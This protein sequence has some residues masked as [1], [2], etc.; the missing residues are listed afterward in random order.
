MGCITK[1]AAVE[2]ATAIWEYDP[3][4]PD[5]RVLGGSLDVIAAVRTIAIKIQASGQRIE[6]FEWLQ[7]NCQINNLL[8]IP[9]HS[10]VQWGLAYHMLDCSYS[11]R[12][13]I[14]LFLKL[15]DALYGPITTDSRALQHRFSSEQLP[16]LWRALPEIKELQTAWEAKLTKI[17]LAF[18]EKPAY[19]LALALH[20]YYK[21]EYIKMA[22]GGAEEQAEEIQ[23]GNKEAKNWQ[24][25]AQKILETTMQEYYTASSITSPGPSHMNAGGPATAIESKSVMSDFDRFHLGRVTKD[26]DERWAPE[27]RCYLK[28]LPSDVTKETDIV[29]WWQD[30]AQL[31]L[32]LA[33]IALDCYGFTSD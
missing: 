22:W 31:Y 14:N 10:N 3:S 15:A 20:L 5:N 4:L 18:D 1:I 33:R 9:L 16:T 21:L 13:P 7:S 28:E 19:V 32:M 24:D 27:L 30:H 17:L 11:L 26:A 29:K 2:N 8:R 25:K 23:A 6:Y 12:K